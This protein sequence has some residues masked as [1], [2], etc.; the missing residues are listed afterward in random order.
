VD[1]AADVRC[2]AALARLG[3]E[4]FG[5]IL[6]D[7]DADAANEVGERVRTAIS[8]EFGSYTLPP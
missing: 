1:L 4:E 7:T 8:T 6:P 2:P 3:G 5:V